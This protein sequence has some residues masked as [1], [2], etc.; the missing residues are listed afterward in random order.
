MVVIKSISKGEGETIVSS[1]VLAILEEGAVTATPASDDKSEP[2][3]APEPAA[4][5]GPVEDNSA[6]EVLM[7]PA[8]KKGDPA[9]QYSRAS[10]ARNVLKQ[11]RCRERLKTLFRG[12]ST[13]C[14]IFVAVIL[15]SAMSCSQVAW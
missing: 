9:G 10:V 12:A 8:A 2:E 5:S 15:R 1:E 3:T 14:D 11:E 4:G 7:S 13:R 6:V